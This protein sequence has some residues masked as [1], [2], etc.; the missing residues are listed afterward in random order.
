LIDQSV[1][2]NSDRVVE[3][4]ADP[5]LVTSEERH[6]NDIGVGREPADEPDRDTVP[7]RMRHP[8]ERIPLRLTHPPQSGC[9]RIARWWLGEVL[10][11]LERGGD[12]DK[13]LL[14]MLVPLIRSRFSSVEPVAE[15]RRPIDLRR[16]IM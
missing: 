6:H 4:I 8:P 9:L 10:E 5:G 16:K 14:G 7:V 15:V 1:G 13:Y 12:E 2:A 11:M 3:D